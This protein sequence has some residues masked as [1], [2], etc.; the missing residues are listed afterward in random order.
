MTMY[1]LRE[2]Y[3]DALLSFKFCVCV[4]FLNKHL[5]LLIYSI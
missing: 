3:T 4:C 1:I 2:K 5:K